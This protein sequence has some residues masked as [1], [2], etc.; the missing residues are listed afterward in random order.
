[1]RRQRSWGYSVVEALLVILLATALVP[2]GWALLSK[3]RVVASRL[4]SRAE[5]LETV[6]TLAW[7]LAEEVDGSLEGR[8][9][10]AMGEDSIH[11]RAFRG[12]ALLD[13]AIP[14][15]ATVLACFR[16]TRDPAP[17]KDSVLVLGVDG[18]WRAH[19]LLSRAPASTDCEEL[20][21]GGTSELWTLSSDPGVAVLARVFETG[22]YHLAD[23]ALRYRRGEGGR[24][25][26]TPEVIEAGRFIGMG[27]VG[28]PLAWEIRLQP[29]PGSGARPSASPHPASLWKGRVR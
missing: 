5:A 1:M 8:D 10:M 15:Q 2:A 19:D 29:L 21:D 14:G 3:Q 16:G 23:G 13:S 25:P 7:I 20:V 17:E 9:W 6:R 12:H 27:A 22:S 4:V 28:N 24:Q 11:L 26:L 18:R